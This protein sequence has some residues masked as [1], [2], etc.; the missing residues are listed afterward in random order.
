[1][2]WAADHKIRTVGTSLS[3]LSVDWSVSE[4]S[5]TERRLGLFICE[6][7]FRRR[8]T[9]FGVSGLGKGWFSSIMKSILVTAPN[10]ILARL[11]SQDCARWEFSVPAIWGWKVSKTKWILMLYL[12]IMLCILLA[13]VS[14]YLTRRGGCAHMIFCQFLAISDKFLSLF[15]TNN[16]SAINAEW[17]KSYPINR[18]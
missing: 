5:G 3:S 6:R 18:K 4:R 17:I 13:A 9:T 7:M 11:S 14:P 1:M 12:T 10:L 2:G 15:Y 16:G 8:R